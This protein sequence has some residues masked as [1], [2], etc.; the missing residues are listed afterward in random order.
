MATH[1]QTLA[2]LDL[3]ISEARELC[4]R[5]ENART[6]EPEAAVSV[7]FQTV[8]GR[9]VRDWMFRAEKMVRT[10]KPDGDRLCGQRASQLRSL[11]DI[12]N[13][14]MLRPSESRQSW[15]GFYHL[16]RQSEGCQSKD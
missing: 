5:A 13:V 8:L 7:A 4:D 2:R 6:G 11:I 14:A 15:A 9:Q 3:L 16:A 12:S 10:V 1:H